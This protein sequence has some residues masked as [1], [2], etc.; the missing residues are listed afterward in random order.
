MLCDKVMSVPLSKFE[1]FGPSNN[2]GSRP[3]SEVQSLLPRAQ[4]F[5]LEDDA[6]GAADSVRKGHAKSLMDAD[7]YAKLP[8]ESCWYEWN[9]DAV[10][11][12]E[13]LRTAPR[14]NVARPSKVGLLAVSENGDLGQGKLWLV[15]SF[16]ESVN[17]S[18]LSV[19]FRFGEPQTELVRE[20]SVKEIFSMRKTDKAMRSSVRNTS[21][22]VAL[23]Q[24]SRQFT[25][26]FPEWD[27]SVQ[28]WV[29]RAGAGRSMGDDWSGESLFFKSLLILMN[30]KNGIESERADLGKLNKSRVKSGKTELFSHS[31]VRLRLSHRYRSAVAHGAADAPSGT[32]WHMVRGHFKTRKSGVF[33]WSP[34][35]RGD[36]AMGAVTHDYRVSA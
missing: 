3:Y 6:A 21:D 35:E 9:Y 7:L 26:L 32:R 29:S 36:F 13:Q 4:K 33:W 1:A 31:I 30:C 5:V 16:G 10:T 15:W 20:S 8:F 2:A 17:I 18:P 28:E 27:R 11:E 24:I 34:F 12:D 14:H 19:R 23:A 25:P 22:A